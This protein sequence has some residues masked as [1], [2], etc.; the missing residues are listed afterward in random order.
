MAISPWRRARQHFSIDAPRM[1]VRSRLPWP[2]RAM[3][4]VTLFALVAGMWWW[5]FD[6]GQIFGGF[7]RREIESRV[8]ALETENAELRADNAKLRAANIRQESELAMSAGTQ[9]S[10]SKQA[11]Q[12]QTENSQIKEELVFLQTLVADSNKQGGLAIQRVVVEPEREDAWH[13]SLLLVRGGNPKEEF[14]GHV[15]LQV[16][17]HPAVADGPIALPAIVTLPDDQP[18]TAAA[19]KL[20]FKYYQRLEGTIVVPDGAW[21]RAVTVRAFESGQASPKATRNLVIP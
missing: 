20:K 21:V 13:Y 19:L 8:A 15:T 6:F 17:L 4:V 18:Q 9:V 14:D 10:L 12:L 7:N 1:A 3:A 16:M 2:W 11:L 5:G